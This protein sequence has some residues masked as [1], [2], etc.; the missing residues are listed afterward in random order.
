MII[1]SGA[2]LIPMD[3]SLKRQDGNFVSYRRQSNDRRWSKDDDQLLREL[4]QAEF[5][6]R[7]IARELRRTHGPCA[8]ER[9]CSTL[10]S[11]TPVERV[12]LDDLS[13]DHRNLSRCLA[14]AQAVTLGAER[15][16]APG[17][18]CPKTG[19]QTFQALRMGII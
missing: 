10:I 14:R 6:S 18:V 7:A 9:A 1:D 19:T 5:N 4:V 15:F 16:S 11:F 12:N 3:S 8:I 13:L 2:A 17:V